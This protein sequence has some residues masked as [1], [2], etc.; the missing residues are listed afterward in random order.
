M[1]IVLVHLKN[2]LH[3]DMLLHLLFWLQVSL[4]LFALT[5]SML[6]DNSI[7]GENTNLIVSHLF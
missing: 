1:F 6:C 7:E 5:P 4:L 3:V 2:N